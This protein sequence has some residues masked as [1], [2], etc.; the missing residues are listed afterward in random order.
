MSR[1]SHVKLFRTPRKSHVI[2]RGLLKMRIE[3]P[4]DD[5]RKKLYAVGILKNN[6]P[7]PKNVWKGYTHKQILILYNSVLRG[8]LNYYSFVHNYSR[9]ATYLY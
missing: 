3:A 4:L 5:I 7:C 9:L 1:Q 2:Q 8:Y 6:R